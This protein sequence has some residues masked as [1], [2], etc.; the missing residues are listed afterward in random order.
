MT[1]ISQVVRYSMRTLL[2]G[3]MGV[4]AGCAFL[5]RGVLAADAALLLDPRT[6][7]FPI[8]E[9]FSVRILLDAGDR[10]VGSA[11]VTI[12]YEPTDLVFVS[13]ATDGS[14][15]SSLIEDK[16]AGYGRVRI[17]GV[18][19]KNRGPF[20][21]EGGLV[22][23]LTFRPLRNVATQ[24][25]FAQGSA[26]PLVASVGDV[27]SNILAAPLQSATYTLVPKDVVPGIAAVAGVG[28]GQGVEVTPIPVPTGEWFA[29]TSVKLTWSLPEQAVA[30]RSDVSRDAAGNPTTVYEVPV[31]SVTTPTLAEGTSYFLLQFKVGDTWGGVTRFPLK[32]DLSPP[33]L[34]LKEASREDTTDPRVAFAV[35]ASDALSGVARYDVALDS[36]PQTAWERPESGRYEPNDLAPGDH[37]LTVWAYDQAGN[38]TSTELSFSVASLESPILTDIPDRLLAGDTITVHGTTYPDAHV[39]VFTAFNNGQAVETQVVS[40]AGGAFVA[41]VSDGARAGTYTVWFSVTD[42][43]GATSPL[44]I[45]RSVTVSQPFIMLFGSLAVTYL[46]VIVPLLALI[47]LLALAVWL[48]YTW[49]RG[50]R[51]R[52]RRETAEAYGAVRGEFENLRAEIV[53]QIGMLERAQQD[54]ELTKEEMRIF[55]DLSKRLDH[56][57]AHIEAEIED[58][59]TVPQEVREQPVAPA[60]REGEPRRRHL[61]VTDAVREQGAAP[62]APL[63][64]APGAIHLSP[65]RGG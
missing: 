17:Q 2:I 30:Q 49:V 51:G 15:F 18:V 23:T 25:W 36:G 24:V 31:S 28:A 47:A 54:R 60:A 16:D 50:Y 11:D 41:N 4:L 57:E 3:S 40:D 38:S 32:V 58:I 10:S 59:E 29:T 26:V 61:A 27:V 53:K 35:D 42:S 34:A 20:A 33:A 62:S 8:G 56:I 19:S 37:T 44:S 9:E 52:V 45:K 13:Y 43:R 48:G 12:G 55:V 39:T 22:A 65:R 63:S 1:I 21:G 7:V 64:P 5:P 46:S 14:V 6:G